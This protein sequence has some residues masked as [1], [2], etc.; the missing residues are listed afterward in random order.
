MISIS[1]DRNLVGSLADRIPVMHGGGRV[2]EKGLLASTPELLS[3]RV[4]RFAGVDE[5][6]ADATR[7]E[8]FGA[9]GGAGD[10]EKLAAARVHARHGQA[11]H[12]NP[13]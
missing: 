4:A 12:R 6:T 10:L 2:I 8:V 11:R 9:P 3:P 5:G 7:A 1:R 13:P